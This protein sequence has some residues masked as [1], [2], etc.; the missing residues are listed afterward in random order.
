MALD[1]GQA[2]TGQV[3]RQHVEAFQKSGLTRPV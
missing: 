3:W 1:T 2:T